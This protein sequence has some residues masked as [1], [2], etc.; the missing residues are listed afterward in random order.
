MRIV[1]ASGDRTARVWDFA[2]GEEVHRFEHGSWVR[3]VQLAGRYV[4]STSDDRTARV[5]DIE[6]GKLVHCIAASHRI[7]CCAVGPRH[8]AFGTSCGEVLCVSFE[9]TARADAFVG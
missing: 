6:S 8:L 7:A 1:S 4:V 2:T 5:W 9:A 3:S